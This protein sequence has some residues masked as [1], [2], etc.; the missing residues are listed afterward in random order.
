[1][2][3]FT[4][5]VLVFFFCLGYQSSSAQDW[6][7]D[8]GL[9]LGLKV[10]SGWD[11]RRGGFGLHL[12]LSHTLN[13]KWS[14]SF[15]YQTYGTGFFWSP[16]G[17]TL[18]ES[19]TD[20]FEFNETNSNLWMLNPRYFF[21]SNNSDPSFLVGMAFGIQGIKRAVDVNG[22]KSISKSVFTIVPEIGYTLDGFI[23]ALRWY[24]GQETPTFE[25]L[26]QNDGRRKV[27]EPVRFSLITIHFTYSIKLKKRQTK[28]N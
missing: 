6:S 5:I 13:T 24:P 9:G 15:A 22:I 8:T 1:M 20:F 25:A 19:D 27:F 2:K 10:P 3:P 23:L 17:P 4:R 16:D 26:D 14:L 18:S 28:A 12:G 21:G 11:E 7:L